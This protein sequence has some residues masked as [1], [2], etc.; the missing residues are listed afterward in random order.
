[1]ECK[2]FYLEDYPDGHIVVKVDN[3]VIS[4]AKTIQISLKPSF[5]T[6]PASMQAVVE[7]DSNKLEWVSEKWLIKLGQFEIVGDGTYKGT[8]VCMNSLPLNLISSVEISLHTDL[9]P[10]VKLGYIIIPRN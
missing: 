8:T 4:N 9:P 2:E 7:T 10:I 1:M 6:N 3:E 5:S